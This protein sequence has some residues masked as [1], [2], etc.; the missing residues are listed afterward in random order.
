MSADVSVW[1]RGDWAC[2]VLLIYD[3]H[4]RPMAVLWCIRAAIEQAGDN[5]SALTTLYIE[6]SFSAV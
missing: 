2:L 5:A 6:H 3:I 4:S 1:S